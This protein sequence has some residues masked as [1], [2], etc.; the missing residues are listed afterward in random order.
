MFKKCLALL[1][2]LAFIIGIVPVSANAQSESTRIQAEIF[3]IYGLI[4]Q[5]TGRWDL[6]GLCGTVTGYQLYY[7]GINDSP[8]IL[9][10]RDQYDAYK[11]MEFTTGGHRVRTYSAEA[12]SLREALYDVSNGGTKDVYNLL[13]GFQWTRSWAG[14]RYGH[15]VVIYAI[16]DGKVYFCEGFN[17]PFDKQVGGPSICT[18]DEF[19][20]EYGQWSVFEGLIHF[21]QKDGSELTNEYACNAFVQVNGNGEL[22]SAPSVTQST[23]L[24]TVKPGE[25]LEAVGIFENENKELYYRI[26]DSGK[27]C[28]IKVEDVR[29]FSMRYD[30]VQIKDAQYPELLKPG[31]NY[32]I[33][34]ILKSTHNQT[35]N[36]MARIIDE[37][38]REVDCFVVPVDGRYKDLSTSSLRSEINFQNLP[39]GSYSL[40][41]SAEVRNHS[42]RGGKILAEMEKCILEERV[43][44]VGYSAPDTVETQAEQRETVTGWQYAEGKWYYYEN[45]TPRTGWLC[46]KGVDYYLL[47]DGSAATGWLE[48]NGKMRFFSDTG[49]MRTGWL[50]DEG[51]IYYLL[52]N[53]V[54]ATGERTIDGVTHMFGIDGIRIDPVLWQK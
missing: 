54:P 6:S 18:I 23:V 39:I 22:W 5:V 9:D 49:A 11:N 15:A 1:V 17:T 16:L 50:D 47:E 41:I 27:S 29:I 24:R 3:R 19:A 25:R 45:G 26:L 36:V 30:D 35:H 38:G 52:S 12:Y 21:G 7:L 40:E 43:F 4:Q 33:N 46:S 44:T 8:V 32:Q 37:M 20:S 34:G 31:E 10:G 14:Q 51:A 13:A 53:G 48:V 42:V 28:Y 2:L